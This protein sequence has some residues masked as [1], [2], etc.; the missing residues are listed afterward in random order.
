MTNYSG[1]A[2]IL[3]GTLSIQTGLLTDPK[4]KRK[5]MHFEAIVFDFD[6]TIA[7][8][9]APSPSGTNVNTA[10]KRAIG[11]IFGTTGIEIFDSLGGLQ[12]RAPIEIIGALIY[13]RPKLIHNMSEPV[14]SNQSNQDQLSPLN[15]AQK[16]YTFIILVIITVIFIL[17]S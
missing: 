6:E 14:L 17:I 4:G 11:Q 3:I 10:T 1:F 7:Q 9:F 12:N 5:N 13:K 15:L 2:N 8:T 16:S